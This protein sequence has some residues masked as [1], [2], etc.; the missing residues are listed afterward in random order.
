MAKDSNKTFKI[1]YSR[2]TLNVIHDRNTHTRMSLN[3]K[4]FYTIETFKLFSLS[5]SYNI[6]A[7]ALPVSDAYTLSDISRIKSLNPK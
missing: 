3:E 1:I 5:L 6:F 2:H 7:P 4:Y